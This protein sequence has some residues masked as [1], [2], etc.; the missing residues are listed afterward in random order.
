M[1]SNGNEQLLCQTCFL[2][3]GDRCVIKTKKRKYIGEFRGT[4]LPDYFSPNRYYNIRMDNGEIK[5]IID[6]SIISIENI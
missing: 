4:F 3:I 6:D 1:S 5:H 2:Q